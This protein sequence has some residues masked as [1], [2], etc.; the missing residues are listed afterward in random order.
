MLKKFLGKMMLLPKGL[1]FIL[2]NALFTSISLLIFQIFN[3]RSQNE[4]IHLIKKSRCYIKAKVPFDYQLNQTHTSTL[5]GMSI[6][7]SLVSI[8][9]TRIRQFK[10][11]C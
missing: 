9:Q 11:Y 5:P 7:M 1:L 10:T 6:I 8:I 4:F 2:Q 3:Y